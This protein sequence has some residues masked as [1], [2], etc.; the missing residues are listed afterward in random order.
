MSKIQ[1]FEK[2]GPFPLKEIIKKIGFINNDP[3]FKVKTLFFQFCILLE[4]FISRIASASFRY[5]VMGSSVLLG[6]RGYK[7]SKANCK[8]IA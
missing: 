7:Y 1:F 4:A 3:S 5:G 2:K 6:K 8:Q